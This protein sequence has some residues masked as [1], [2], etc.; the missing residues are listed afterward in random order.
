MPCRQEDRGESVQAQKWRQY[1]IY[2][3]ALRNNQYSNWSN[4]N[5]KDFQNF[6]QN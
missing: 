4:A 3:K 6:D 1:N 2:I 5:I